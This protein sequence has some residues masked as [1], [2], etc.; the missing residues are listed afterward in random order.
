MGLPG[1]NYEPGT[2]SPT[3]PNAIPIPLKLLVDLFSHAK[4]LGKWLRIK[5]IGLQ[6][7]WVAIPRHRLITD[8]PG[9]RQTLLQQDSFVG[10]RLLSIRDKGM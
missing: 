8:L 5:G 2:L 4:P 7:A 6:Q 9:L 1:W 10:H 3:H